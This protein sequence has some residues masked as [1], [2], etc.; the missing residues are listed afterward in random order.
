MKR[1]EDIEARRQRLAADLQA[2]NNELTQVE[3]RVAQALSVS[4]EELRAIA[5]DE[6]RKE[7]EDKLQTVEQRLRSIGEPASPPPAVLL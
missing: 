1:L 5:I 6:A 7:C 2:R 4:E 3:D